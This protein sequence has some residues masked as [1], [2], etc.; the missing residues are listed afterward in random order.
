MRKSQWVSGMAVVLLAFAGVTA[1]SGVSRAGDSACGS[2]NS[3][4]GAPSPGSELRDV[5]FV[6]AGESWAVGDALD[7]ATGANQALIERYNGSG[8]SVVPSPYRS[9]MSNG[10]N[11][12]SIE[13]GG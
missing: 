4:K 7:R 5:A 3:G 10:L 12:V 13:S 9:T 2:L 6:S 1:G 11:G 8:W